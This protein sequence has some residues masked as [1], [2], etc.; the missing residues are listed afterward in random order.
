MESLS[1]DLKL[2]VIRVDLPFLFSSQ[3]DLCQT[4]FLAPLSQNRITFHNLIHNDGQVTECVSEIIKEYGSQKLGC[5][6]AVKS[7]IYQLIVLLL[8][9]HVEKILSP[10]EFSAKMNSLKHFDAVLQYISTHYT[11]KISEVKDSLLRQ[12][13]NVV[14]GYGIYQ[15]YNFKKRAESCV[16]RSRLNFLNIF[17]TAFLTVPSERKSVFA[18]SRLLFP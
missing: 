7:F 14:F 8:R 12:Y 2:Y 11:E 15:S 13:C 16:L 9:R 3:I 6:L 18:I 10:K 17:E 1:D 5:E 4:K